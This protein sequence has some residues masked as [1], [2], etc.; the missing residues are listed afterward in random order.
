VSYGLVICNQCKREVHQDGSPTLPNGP[1][2]WRHCEDKTPRCVGAVSIYP[3]ARADIAGKWCGRDEMGSPEE[4]R[5]AL[6]P[7][8][9]RKT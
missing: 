5:G 8:A 2:T 1:N 9:R 7:R 4:P 6:K 3:S